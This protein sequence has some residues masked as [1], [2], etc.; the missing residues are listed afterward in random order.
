[1]FNRF[2][3]RVPMPKSLQRQFMLA[4]SGQAVLIV[5]GALIAVYGMYFSSDTTKRLAEERLVHLQGT[6][7]L[8]AHAL[9][10]ERGAYNLLT[11]DSYDRV[12]AGYLEILK[13]IDSLDAIVL[14]LGH[15]ENNL[16]VLDLYQ[17]SQLLRNTVHIVAQL[18]LNILNTPGDFSGPANRQETL[19]HFHTGL[20]L[21]VESLTAATH[22]LS[23]RFTEDYQDGI[24]QLTFKSARDQRRVLAFLAGSVLFAWL[25][26]RYFLG[27]HV[28]MRL[29]RISECLKMDETGAVP[30]TVP[31][32][33]E[34]EISHM[35]RA[36]NRFL[37]ERRLLAEAQHS[38]RE[39]EETLRA[40]IDAAPAAIIDLDLDGNI[41]S[42]WNQAAE[43]M[44]GWSALEVMG[45]PFPVLAEG[46]EEFGNLQE[47]IKKGL[48]LN[49]HEA[50]R[51]K[52]DGTIVDYSIHAAPL[53]DPEGR[54][55]GNIGVLV[56]ITD[57]KLLDG[58]L[59]QK[60]ADLERSNAEL[61]DFAYIVSHD[62]K[63]P[64]RSI[65][66]FSSFLLEDHRENLN[67][68]GISHL[69]I[70]RQ[71]AKR[72][73]ALLDD[74]LTYSRVGRV[75]MAK[76]PT[77]LSRVVSGVLDDLRTLLAEKN[78][79][80]LVAKDMPKV[81]CDHV[82][83]GEVFR[84]LIENAVKYNDHEKK[85]IE[86]GWLPDK[87]SGK[88]VPVFY[89]RDNGIGIREKY[90]DTVF[91]IFKR[92]HGREEYGGGTGSGLTITRK[93]VERHRGRIWIESEFGRGSTFY[94]TLGPDL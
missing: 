51:K 87:K 22:D 37:D 27:R 43:K 30:Q 90:L 1:M 28:V 14:C 66:S 69:D 2:L 50:C 86:V 3:N 25:F 92:L 61:E 70:V 88:G 76:Q 36:V 39:R 80:V 82:R 35:A 63:E 81:I 13:K 74:L 65:H 75:E 18:R 6:Q 79:S 11:A 64:L 19:R 55:S 52:R 26:S 48:S 62:L 46:L 9:F 47:Q 20:E 91:K 29:R 53:Y 58:R 67:S 89:V 23:V 41:H 78:A 4:L 32:E 56:D 42:I 5:A 77:D 44:F 7:D 71:S 54:V 57:R 40:I 94:F 10:I 8:V 33:G 84:N 38:L 93:I 83:I 45:R 59:Q 15:A 72:M 49:G 24:R 85:H 16:K 31:V 34:D 68:E 21:Q 12:R 60:N 73:E 17:A